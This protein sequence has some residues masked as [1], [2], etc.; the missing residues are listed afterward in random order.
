MRVGARVLVAMASVTGCGGGGGSPDAAAICTLRADPLQCWPDPAHK[1]QGSVRLGTGHTAFEAMPD[2]LNL[3]YGPQGGYDLVAN[4]RM[5]GFDP[6]N[7]EMILDPGNPRTRIRAFFADS[8]IPLNFSAV[9]PFRQAY[10]PLDS[11]DYDYEFREGVP[12][13][14][15]TCWRSNHLIGARVRVELELMD[16][17]GG[18]ASDVKTVTL[19][20]PTGPYPV[21][22]DAPGC[23]H[24]AD[25]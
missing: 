20:P 14:F 19:A 6:G 7:L 4:V 13:V 15:E 3:E 17:C 16:D 23:M 1:P 9:C 25:P 8:N 18:Y 10:K 21:E 22:D 11:G 24:V 12:V 2:T 5:S